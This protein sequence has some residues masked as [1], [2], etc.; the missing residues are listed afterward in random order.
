[1][2]VAEGTALVRFDAAR[3][4]MSDLERAIEASAYE[5]LGVGPVRLVE[6][7]EERSRL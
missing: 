4:S 5:F 2:N 1:M 3:L 6:R 7:D